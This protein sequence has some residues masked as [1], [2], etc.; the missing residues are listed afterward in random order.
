MSTAYVHGVERWNDDLTWTRCG[1]SVD[2]T[3]D[4][5]V[6]VPEKATCPWCFTGTP[7]PKVVEQR[8]AAHRLAY[9]Y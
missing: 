6:D 7:C 4:L 2:D 8:R 9:G 5:L 3:P 1:L